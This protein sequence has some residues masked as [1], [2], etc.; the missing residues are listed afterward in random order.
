[1]IDSARDAMPESPSP[2]AGSSP[3]RDRAVT[4]RDSLSSARGS[5]PLTRQGGRA[6]LE[7]HLDEPQYVFGEHHHVTAFFTNLSIVDALGWERPSA[8]GNP[9]FY[10]GVY[11][12]IVFAAAVM[13]TV[14]STVQ[15]RQTT[16]GMGWC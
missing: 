2:R 3:T 12:A 1:M 4:P 6:S 7:E 13:A 15:V 5:R 9:Y 10:V 11:A 16:G 14:N 8:T